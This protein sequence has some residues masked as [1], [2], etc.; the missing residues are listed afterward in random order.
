MRRDQ[1]G[2]EVATA[3]LEREGSRAPLRGERVSLRPLALADATPLW[4]LLAGA[5]LGGG[6]RLLAPVTAEAARELVVELAHTAPDLVLGIA[7]R[8]D[9]RLVGL[10]G[11]HR[12]SDAERQAELG[13]LVRGPEERGKGFGVEAVRLLCRHG[14]ESLE[15]ARIWLR[16]RADNAPALRAYERAGF[17]LERLLRGKEVRGGE[18]V[19]V[20]VMGLL[21]EEWDAAR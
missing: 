14:F 9:G 13:L 19:D 12:L 16:V 5:E 1:A 15:L 8:D 7:A 17:R 20:V 4:A 10:A 21:R 6:L 2:P 18:R 3:P 11:L